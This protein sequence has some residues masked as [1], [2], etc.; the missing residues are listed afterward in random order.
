MAV[1]ESLGAILPGLS[2]GTAA[3]LAAALPQMA[4]LRQHVLW[5]GLNSAAG[6]PLN[7]KLSDSLDL[8][9]HTALLLRLP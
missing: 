5:R 6:L 7:T 3:G 2:P 8:L 1:L 4:S 9:A